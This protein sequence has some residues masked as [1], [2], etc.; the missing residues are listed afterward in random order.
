MSSAISH[1]LLNRNWDKEEHS[2]ESTN[3]LFSVSGHFGMSNVFE[4]VQQVY[5][6][7]NQSLI[8]YVFRTDTTIFGAQANIWVFRIGTT[9]LKH[10][11]NPHSDCT[12][13]PESR[14]TQS[15][16][17]LLCASLHSCDMVHVAPVEY[18]IILTE[19]ETWRQY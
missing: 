16:I 17:P 12:L 4:V 14:L 9:L 15:L 6:E 10:F 1:E 8:V 3:I 11:N 7:R 5:S 13:V 2:F 19:Q 18:N